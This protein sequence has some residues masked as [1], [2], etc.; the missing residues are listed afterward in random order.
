VTNGTRWLVTGA[1]GF[2]GAH[3]VR[4]GL[5]AGAEV[6]AVVRSTSPRGR[7]ADVQRDVVWHHADLTD[8]E[9]T[10]RAVRGARPDLVV[11]LAMPGGHPDT[12]ARRSAMAAGALFGTLNLLEALADHSPRRFVHAGSGLEYGPGEPARES[13]PLLPSVFRGAVKAASSLLVHQWALANE[14][15]TAILRIFSVYGPWEPAGRLVPTAIRAALTGTPMSLTPGAWRDHVYVSDVIDACLRA[16][17]LEA[18]GVSVFNVGSGTATSNA[19]V[20]RAVEQVTGRSVAVLPE[21]APPRVCDHA[22]AVA[23]T[24]VAATGLGWRATT[25]LRD[26]LAQTLRWFDAHPHAW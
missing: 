19:A 7:L 11:H 2:L 23:D 3:L 16:A 25:S 6:H 1:T 20:V 10:R 14:W 4:A 18:H 15:P 13:Q 22:T 17:A 5:A 9:Q 21:A 12:A 26:G 24:S 8:L